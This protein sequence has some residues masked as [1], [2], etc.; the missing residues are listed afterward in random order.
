LTCPSIHYKLNN[1]DGLK[2]QEV[3]VNTRIGITFALALTLGL[4]CARLIKVE[5]PAQVK[6]VRKAKRSPV[7]G[8][9]VNTNLYAEAE[10]KG[11]ISAAAAVFSHLRKTRLNTSPNS[12]KM[13]VSLEKAPAAAAKKE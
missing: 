7:M 5:A 4:A 11:S 13:G 1:Q 10:G 9:A 8:G 12:K 6:S 2:N 3:R